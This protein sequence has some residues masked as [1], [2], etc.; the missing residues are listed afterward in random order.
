MSAEDV[1][2]TRELADADRAWA[3]ALFTL[4]FSDAVIGS[5]GAWFDTRLLPGFV[6]EH[7]DKLAG[8]LVH[9]PLSPGLDC[10]IVA[11]VSEVQRVGA[12]TALLSRCVTAARMAGSRRVFL[13]TSND[14]IDALRFYQRRGW[15]IVAV[16][17]DSISQA[18]AERPSIP[19]VGH[20][21]ILIA[22]ELELE[23]FGE[24]VGSAITPT[25][26]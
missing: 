13:T 10:E 7:Q 14:N 3:V 18:R 25:H 4:H 22:D 2:T 21:G 1:V 24:T 5:R 26:A 16:H 15:R 9:T 20:H 19:L 8:V 23:Y 6:A 11:L 17:R 12:A